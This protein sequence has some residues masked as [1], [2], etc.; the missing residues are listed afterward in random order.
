MTNLAHRRIG[1]SHLAYLLLLFLDLP[2]ELVHL[3][4]EHVGG[5]RGRRRVGGA[6]AR[7]A[8][9]GRRARAVRLLVVG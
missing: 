9:A 6:G 2:V 1:L 8:A 7:A 5:G 4:A 3:G